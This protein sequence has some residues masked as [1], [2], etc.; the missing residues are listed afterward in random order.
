MRG[1]ECIFFPPEKANVFGGLKGNVALEKEGLVGS[2]AQA[3]V[4]VGVGMPVL[5][6]G[7]LLSL[8]HLD[9]R[10]GFSSWLL[11]GPPQGVALQSVWV[12][13]FGLSSAQCS[14]WGLFLVVPLPGTLSW[15]VRFTSNKILGR[16]SLQ[17]CI[18]QALRSE[19]RPCQM[20]DTEG[21]CSAGPAPCAQ[22]P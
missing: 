18:F 7:P 9:G 17:S 5:I 22:C 2:G 15:I 10:R 3:A 14:P 13:G 16:G 11:Q 20:P 21:P 1:V 19:P 8:F 12:T 4:G 6:A